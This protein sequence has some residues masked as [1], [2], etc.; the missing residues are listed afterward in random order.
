LAGEREF[1]K[2]IVETLARLAEMGLLRGRG[3]DKISF[4]INALCFGRRG[5]ENGCR[6]AFCSMFLIEYI[7]S[8][9]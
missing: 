1:F 8:F 5:R 2:T 6:V 9:L 7:L 3:I 4:K